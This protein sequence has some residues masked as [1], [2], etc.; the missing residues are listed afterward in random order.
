M[1]E[2]ARSVLRGLV[3]GE[4]VELSLVELCQACDVG[5]E[6]ISIWVLEGVL[7]PAGSG[8][9]EWRFGGQALRR[10]RLAASFSRELDL[11]VAG[12]AL[13]LD[14]MDEIAS[15]KARLRRLEG[16]GSH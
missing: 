1:S 5:R 8:P 10:A 9:E 2:S 7:E 15:L 12:V 14:L 6:E 11:N 13:A 3:V 4:E 16:G